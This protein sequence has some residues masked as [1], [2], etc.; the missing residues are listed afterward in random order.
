[1]LGKPDGRTKEASRMRDVR[2]DLITHC[3]GNP[4][5]TERGLIEVAVRLTQIVATMPSETDTYVQAC[6]ALADTLRALGP[7][8]AAE[9]AA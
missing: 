6:T 3:G 7:A 9:A 5:A 4:T 8:R 1:V 2:N